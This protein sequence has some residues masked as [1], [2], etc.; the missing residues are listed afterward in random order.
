MANNGLKGVLKD[1]EKGHE[2]PPLSAQHEKEALEPLFC[3]KGQIGDKKG[4]SKKSFKFMLKNYKWAQV[5]KGKTGS[6]E[7]KWYVWYSFK[8]P[9]TLKY[10]RIRVY[11]GINYINDLK[12]KTDFSE[13]LSKEINKALKAGYNP[14]D[15][16]VE[17][18]KLIDEKT[19]EKH[20]E[21]N[22]KSPTLLNAF[23]EFLSV[24]RK[25]NLSGSTIQTYESFINRFEDYLF[26]NKLADVRL[27][28]IDTHFIK[29]MLQDIQ[30]SNKL[31]GTTFNN[32]INFWVLLLNWFARK[33][34]FW[35]NREDFDIG[36][37][38][39]L[40]PQLSKPMKNQYF[41]DTVAEKVKEKM[42]K[43]PKLLFFS[44]FIYFSCMRPDEIRNLKIENVDVTGRYIKIVGKTSSR[45]IP[46]SDELA[47]MLESLN[48]E[49]YPSNYYVI[50]KSGIVSD[51]MH[52]ENYFTR[53]FRE[54]IRVPLKLSDNYTMYGFKHTRVLHLLNAGYSDAE[55]MGL[56]GHRDTASYDKYKRDLIGNLTNNKLRGKTIG[57]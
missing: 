2:N 3:V 16:E 18:I 32:Y 7:E 53:V 30:I 31:N 35:V 25:K 1:I 26:E 9:F 8:N 23:K 5:Y 15:V 56:T 4:T 21:E 10:D 39:E 37:D 51:N 20:L 6:V 33:P 22:P 19:A 43:F 24:K 34:R 29:S 13:E 50:G 48:L 57:W 45:T 38:G 12:E 54:E 42:K 28:N 14:F 55:I 41:V 11:E 46:I 17:A 40:E 27:D 52:S 49:N 47:E 36:N 44:K